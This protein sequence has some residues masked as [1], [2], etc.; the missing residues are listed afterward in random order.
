MMEQIVNEDFE[1]NI[2]NIKSP[3][4][5]VDVDSNMEKIVRSNS[6]E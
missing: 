6:K 3:D 2:N 4:E 1:K 5:A